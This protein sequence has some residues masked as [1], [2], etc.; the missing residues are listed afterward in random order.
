MQIYTIA[1]R[2]TESYVTPLTNAEVDNLCELVRS[3]TDLKTI[4]YYGTTDY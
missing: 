2:P 1:R 4:G 3:R